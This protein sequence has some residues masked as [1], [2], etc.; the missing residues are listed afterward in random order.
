MAKEPS[1]DRVKV[2]SVTAP[3]HPA[4]SPNPRAA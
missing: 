2:R 3:P 1:I 4:L